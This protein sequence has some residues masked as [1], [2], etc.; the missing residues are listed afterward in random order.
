MTQQDMCLQRIGIQ[1]CLRVGSQETKQLQNPSRTDQKSG[2]T[3]RHCHQ[4]SDLQVLKCRKQFVLFENRK[5]FFI[6]HNWLA[7]YSFWSS[8]RWQN[9]FLQFHTLLYN[10]C[11]IETILIQT[12]FWYFFIWMTC[13][14]MWWINRISCM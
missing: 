9:C 7:M 10:L 1:C 5:L 12:Q 6:K 14:F 13:I 3:R 11:D 8:N 2:Q 4:K